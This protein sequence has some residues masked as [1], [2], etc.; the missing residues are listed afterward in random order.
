MFAYNNYYSFNSV[1]YKSPLQHAMNAVQPKDSD[2]NSGHVRTAEIID[3]SIF[4]TRNST[5]RI[6]YC[7]K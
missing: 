2:S 4:H 7:N 5:I 3:Y 6:W 1:M